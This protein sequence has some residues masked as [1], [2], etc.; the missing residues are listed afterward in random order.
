MRIEMTRGMRTAGESP[1]VRKE[2]VEGLL[3]GN[4]KF[5]SPQYCRTSG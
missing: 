5:I 2:T 1:A 4:R 3:A